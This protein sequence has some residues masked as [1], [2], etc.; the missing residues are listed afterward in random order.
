MKD[1]IASRV[2]EKKYIRLLKSK[3]KLS[4]INYDPYILLSIKIS[5]CIILF[6]S[7]I[8]FKIG[9]II[10]PII[11]LLFYYLFD[12]LLIDRKIKLR[13][14]ILNEQSQDFFS[15]LIL[16]LESNRSIKLSIEH[17]TN[18]IKN[19]LSI[20]FKRV[21]KDLDCGK[22]LEESLKELERRI[23]SENINNIILTIRETNKYGNNPT[24]SIKNQLELIKHDNKYIKIKNIKSKNIELITTS[25]VFTLLMITIIIIF[26]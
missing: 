9:Y 21:L 13:E 19:D 24:E 26:K 14:H 3:I 15:L 18:I 4:G 23:P 16:S 17:V 1:N 25:I 8:I 20:E 2:Y 12:Y 10:S 5:L 6:I 22:S 11:T 7:L